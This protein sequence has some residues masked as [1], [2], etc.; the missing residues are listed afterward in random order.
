MNRLTLRLLVLAFGL[1]AVSLVVFGRSAS[2]VRPVAPFSR[3]KVQSGIDVFL[4]EGAKESLRVEARGI[5]L[6]DV[7]SRVD[8]G[9]LVLE[10]R[11]GWPGR[12][13]RPSHVNVYL[14]F[15]DLTQVR[16]SGGSDIKGG[17]SLQLDSLQVDAS[18]GSDVDLDVQAESLRFTLSGGSDLVLKGTAPSLSI[19]ASGGSDV[20][21]GSF[22]AERARLRLS[23][24]SDATIRATAAVDIGARGGSDV[25]IHGNPPAKQISNDRSSDIVWR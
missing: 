25:T 10:R 17:A 15:V 14:G 13:I 22:E 24:G 23:G 20:A 9:E 18:G 21:A 8:G 16:A 11:G 3:L 7:I 19:E 12:L 6:E 5:D 4:T 2:A 1:I